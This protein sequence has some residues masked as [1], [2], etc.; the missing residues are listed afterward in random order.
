MV[1][2]ST[3]SRSRPPNVAKQSVTVVTTSGRSVGRP[4]AL[5]A[6]MD[7]LEA[8]H[9]DERRHG[10]DECLGLGH[11]GEEGLQDGDSGHEDPR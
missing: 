9:R 1:A 8:R 4:G 5:E 11:P 10:D 2:I 7:G 3:S 6:A